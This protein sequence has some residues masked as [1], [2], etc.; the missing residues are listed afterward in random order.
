MLRVRDHL[1]TSTSASTSSTGGSTAAFAS[2]SMPRVGRHLILLY[3]TE[4]EQQWVLGRD[5]RAGDV[6]GQ[7]CHDR[8]VEGLGGRDT[9]TTTTTTTTTTTR[10]TNTSSSVLGLGATAAGNLVGS[11]SPSPNPG[12]SPSVQ[13][14]SG[15]VQALNHV[16]HRPARAQPTRVCVERLRVH[17]SVGAHLVLVGRW[18][19]RWHR[20]RRR[21][22]RRWCC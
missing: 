18:R 2:S 15:Q 20:R 4:H 10:S 9:S 22:R 8:P 7:A 11:P 6:R 16:S 14:V 19:W 13:L 21:R 17:G 5:R 3:W 1:S 12:P